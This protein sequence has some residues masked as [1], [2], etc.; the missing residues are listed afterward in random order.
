MHM[1]GPVH[2]QPTFH[3]APNPTPYHILRLDDGAPPPLGTCYAS[4][5]GQSGT[6][7]RFADWPWEPLATRHKLGAR[8]LAMIP[9][10]LLPLP[11]AILTSNGL[12]NR[13]FPAEA[14]EPLA[15]RTACPGW[16][17]CLRER[18]LVDARQHLVGDFARL[19]DSLGG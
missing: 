15:T 2:G 7:S 3:A 17:L 6:R 4:A 1:I 10:T 8:L 14:V 9:V 18:S 12:P 19:P 13:I 11:A 5:S 16:G